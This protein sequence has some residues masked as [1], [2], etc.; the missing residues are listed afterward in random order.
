MKKAAWI[1]FSLAFLISVVSLTA[2]TYV[3]WHKNQY[4]G[5]IIRMT[6][7]EIVLYD[8]RVGERVVHISAETPIRRGREVK[9]GSLQVGERVIVFGEQHEGIIEATSITVVK[10]GEWS[11]PPR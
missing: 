8:V 9:T 7:N 1:L 6:N 4:F 2:H 3:Q 10:S 5:E 11:V